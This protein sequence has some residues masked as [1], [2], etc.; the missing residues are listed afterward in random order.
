M[1]SIFRKILPKRFLQTELLKK[2][3]LAGWQKRILDGPFKGMLYVDSSIGSAFIPKILGTYELELEGVIANIVESPPD[4]LLNL[5]AAEGYYTVGFAR[6]LPQAMITSWEVKEEGRNLTRQ[7]AEVNGVEASRLN[8]QGFC[9]VSD[10]RNFLGKIPQDCSILVLA[11]IEGG[12]AMLLDPEVIPRLRDCAFLIELHEFR[13]PGVTNVLI[14]RFSSTHSIK[15]IDA[16]ARKFSDWPDDFNSAK[17]AAWN[18]TKVALMNE[19]RPSGMAWLYLMPY[20]N[21]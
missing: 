21:K 10:F 3:V 20:K 15:K 11:D 19:R 9:S 8:I 18:G 14:D 2:K 13:V 12:E 17:S 7:L 6:A 5:G 1:K 16:V 4:H